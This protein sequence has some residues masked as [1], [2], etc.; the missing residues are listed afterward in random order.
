MRKR[1]LLITCALAILFVAVASAH[2]LFLKLDDYFVA[3][4]AQLRIAVLNGTFTSSEA[5]LTSDRLVDI[6]VVGPEGRTKLD[7]AA[8]TVGE[9]ASALTIRT[10]NPGTY[11]VGVSTLPRPISLAA[12][13]F[14]EYLEHDG[15]PDVLA[16]RTKSGEL[17]K[18]VVE[19]YQKHVKTLFQ[20]GTE[21]SASFSTVLEYPAEIVPLENPYNLR[22]GDRLRV[23]CLVD[24][25]AVSNQFVVAGGEQGGVAI[26]ERTTRSDDDGV[27]TFVIDSPGKWYIQFIHMIPSSSTEW[28]YESKWATLTFAVR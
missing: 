11:V 23:R 21:Q 27:A 3:A 5:A 2:N 1:T 14:N 6:S 16:A 15:I 12:A 25:R 24:G 17:G 20:V 13:D 28:N 10:G 22:V 8:W 18:N 19:Y 26:T 9:N 4:G 7:T